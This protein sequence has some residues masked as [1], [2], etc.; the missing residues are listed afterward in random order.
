MNNSII[1]AIDTGSEKIRGIVVQKSSASSSQ[2]K[3]LAYA[4]IPSQGVKRGKIEDS[5]K[6][7][8]AIARL[9]KKLEAEARAQISSVVVNIG[10]H[11]I[12]VKPSKTAIAIS[13]AD[14]TVS[15]EDVDHLLEEA[16][17]VSLSLNKEVLDVYPKEYIIDD[18]KGIK[19]PQGLKGIKLELEAL[20]SCA[21]SP[22]VKNVVDAVLCSDLEI[23]DIIPSPLAAARAVL[24]SQ[25]KELGVVLVDIGAGTTSMVVFEEGNL[26]DLVI[27][28]VGSSHISNDIAIALR[29]EI[30]IAE[31]I[32]KKFGALIFKKTNRK[33]KIKLE[34]G[35]VFD[36]S[37][38]DFTRAAKSRVDQIFDLVKKELKKISKS[39]SLPGGIVLTGGGSKIP[40]I[41]DY[42]KKTLSL[43]AKVSFP[44]NFIGPQLDETSSTVCGLALIG[45]AK[46][47][48]VPAEP[49]IIQKIKKFLKGFIP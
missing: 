49:G 25:Q 18:E 35:K 38:K 37:T 5:E 24:A 39:K 8:E 40:G 30:D 10:G 47:E 22:Y 17:N 34:S 46:E 26:V 44:K 41:A 15:K 3:V 13:R 14:Q 33:E 36:F 43:P 2:Y 7:C 28:P 20:V 4:S 23:I 42:A 9:K 6:A 32:K 45:L 12:F 48:E 29:T 16:K 19:D 21:F 27:F 31:K 1:S 11:H